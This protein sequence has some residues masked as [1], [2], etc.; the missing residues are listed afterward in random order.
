MGSYINLVFLLATFSAVHSY[1]EYDAWINVELHHALDSDDPDIFK[2]RANITIPSLNS[3]LSNVVQEDLSNEDVEKIKSL[4]VKNGFYRMKAIVEYPNGVK[5]TFST[6]NKA[7]SILSAQ[8]NDELWIAIDGS[9]F[10]NAI[11]LSTSGV[12]INECSLFDFS[13]STRQYNTE[14][15]IK[16]T[17]L[18]PVAD[19]A[20]F[21]QKIEREREARERGEVKDNRGFFA[22]YWIYIVPVVI[23]LFVSGA[24]NPDQ[25]K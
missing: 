15:L 14:V 21:I 13:L 7:C 3:G 1:I 10:V 2:Y 18:A 5:R 9:G 11:T 17:E 6:A 20:S 23:L 16:H 12:D 4:A 24:A 22:K 25:Q 8:L 19:T